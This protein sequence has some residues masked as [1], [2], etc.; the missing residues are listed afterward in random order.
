MEELHPASLQFLSRYAP[1]ETSGLA[2]NQALQYQMACHQ[3]RGDGYCDV[4]PEY[5]EHMEEEFK[6]AC[7]ILKRLE[8]LDLTIGMDYAQIQEAG[9]SWIPIKTHDIK[10]QLKILITAE[11]NARDFYASIVEAAMA[12]K[13]F[14]TKKMFESL[15]TDEEKHRN[16]LL[17]IYEGLE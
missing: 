13:D 6:H 10:E 2:S 3:A 7:Q 16:D 12:E 17:R 1:D 9:N 5:T 8:E 11:R 15:M 4:I 14:I